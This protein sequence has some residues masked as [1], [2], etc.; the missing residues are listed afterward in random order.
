MLWLPRKCPLSKWVDGSRHWLQI[1]PLS[2]AV[3]FE[4]GS[5]CWSDGNYIN[6]SDY[7]RNVYLGLLSQVHVSAA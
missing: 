5:N 3:V 6:L 2:L 7:A 4:R 1:V